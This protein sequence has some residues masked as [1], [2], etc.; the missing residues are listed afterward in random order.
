MGPI[1]LFIENILGIREVN[2]LKNRIVWTPRRTQRNGIKNLK[3]GGKNFSLIA[4]PDR[5]EAE[6]SAEQQFTLCLN[7]K[8]ISL[9]AGK[10]IVK[11]D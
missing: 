7:G 2:A 5:N 1:S 6:I 4:Y 11:L 8:E 3:M 9:P 10:S